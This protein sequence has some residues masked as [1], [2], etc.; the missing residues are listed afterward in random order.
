M[1]DTQIRFEEE[2]KNYDY[3]TRSLYFTA[4]ANLKM[5][6]RVISD[7]FEYAT[8]C[9]ELPVNK[10][11]PDWAYVTVSPTKDGSDY[12]W[13][14]IELSNDTISELIDLWKNATFKRTNG[15]QKWKTV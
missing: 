13:S 7:V 10:I 15:R 14:E 4:P 11:T 1:L 8:I 9:I 5:F 3:G 12:D 2:I 6:K